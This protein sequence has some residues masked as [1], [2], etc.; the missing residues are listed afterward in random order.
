MWKPSDLVT[1][2]LSSTAKLLIPS[3][4][5]GGVFAFVHKESFNVLQCSKDYRELGK[6]RRM[7]AFQVFYIGSAV[8]N[9]R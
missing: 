5:E 1:I 2:R 7:N 6:A 4:L 9:L 8:G 3:S